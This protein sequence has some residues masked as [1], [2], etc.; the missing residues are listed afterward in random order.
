L[1]TKNI[2]ISILIILIA[3]GGL[4]ASAVKLQ[5]E[6]TNDRLRKLEKHLRTAR[7]LIMMYCRGD[8]ILK[9]K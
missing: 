6:V 9:Y 8:K 1:Q 5:E 3:T 7:K 2:S 4:Y